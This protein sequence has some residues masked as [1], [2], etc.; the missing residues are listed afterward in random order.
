MT[1]KAQWKK[2]W[3]HVIARLEEIISD[4]MIDFYDDV[5]EIEMSRAE[6]RDHDRMTEALEELLEQ[7]RER[8]D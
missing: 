8:G 4:Y 7:F 5:P 6:D 1:S 3:Y 2:R